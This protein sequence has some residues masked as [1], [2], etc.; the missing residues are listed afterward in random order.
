MVISYILIDF[1]NINQNPPLYRFSVIPVLNRDPGCS[2]HRNIY[3]IP[4]Q[5][6][7]DSRVD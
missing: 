2:K 6:R 3:W 1:L 5:A 7:D 4:C